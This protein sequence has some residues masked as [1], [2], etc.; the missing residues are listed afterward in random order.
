[1]LLACRGGTGRRSCGRPVGPGGARGHA[2]AAAHPDSCPS[3]VS[4]RGCQGRPGR[5]NQI[6]LSGSSCFP[7]IIGLRPCFGAA[8]FNIVI[9]RPPHPRRVSA[10]RGRW[11]RVGGSRLGKRPRA[12]GLTSLTLSRASRH[13]SGWGRGS[14]LEH[15]LFFQHLWAG[16]RTGRE[17]GREGRSPGTQRVLCA[18]LR[19]DC[20][21]GPSKRP[22]ER[23][24]GACQ[25]VCTGRSAPISVYVSVTAWAERVCTC[26]D[27][28]EPLCPP[29]S[30]LQPEAPSHISTDAHPSTPGS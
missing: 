14:T 11:D 18:N 28:K 6:S 30:H 20:G 19:P 2:H 21:A 17:E 29:P 3:W 12:G 1:M 27:S 26:G 8:A 23:R 15:D 16:P 4:L 5:N 22:R 25:C 13:I 24:V 10:N 7:G 9:P